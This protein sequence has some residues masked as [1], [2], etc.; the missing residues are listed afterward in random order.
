[1]LKTKSLTGKSQDSSEQKRNLLTEMIGQHNESAGVCPLSLAQQRLWFLEQLEPS[2]AAHQLCSGLRLTGDL[3]FHVLRCAVASILARHETLRTAFITLGGEVFQRIS[4][5]ADVEIPVVDLQTIPNNLREREAYETACAEARRPFDLQASPLL[6]LKLIKMGRNDYIFLFTMHHLVSDG[7]S[8][9]VFVEELTEFYESRMEGRQCRLPRLSIQ[10]SDF[11]RWQRES[12]EGEELDRQIRYWKTRL[13]GV[14]SLLELPADR[15]RTAEQAFAC[16]ALSAPLS[17][18][19]VEGLKAL[20]QRNDTTLFGVLL[21]AFNV[22]LYRYS[23][24]EDVCVGVS[25][26]GRSHVET[27][28][29]I[30][31]FVNTLVIRTDMSGNPRFRDLLAQVRDVL[32]DAQANQDLPFEKVVEEVQP[33]RSLA[34]HPLFQVMMTA[35][36]DPLRV[37]RFGSLTA[38]PYVVANS[39]SSLDLAAFVIEAA[40]G[41]LWWRLEYNTALFAPA[42]I[43]RMIRHYQTLLNSIVEKPE[44]RIED[45]DLLTLEELDKF[46]AW[47]NNVSKYPRTCVHELIADQ[48]ARSPNGIAVVFEDQSLTYAELHY[49]ARQVAAALRAAGA[50]LDSRVAICLERSLEMAAGVLGILQ[51]GAAYVPLDPAQPLERLSLMVE[52]AGAKLLLTQ[53]HL[54]ARV[55]RFFSS[56]VLIEDASTMAPGAPL[57]LQDPESLAYIMFTSGSTGRP[58]SVAVPHRAIVNLLT[59]MHTEPGLALDDRFLAV[60]NLCFDISALELF[61]PLV[62]GTRTVI[63]AKNVVSDGSKL[64][65]NLRRHGITIMQATPSTWRMLIGAGWNRANCDLKVLC[66]GETLTADLANQLIERSNSVWNLYGPTETTIWSSLTRVREHCPVSIG[67][68][69]QNTQF[70]VLD[71]RMRRVPVGIPGELYIGGDG[72]AAG[73]WNGSG[74]NRD[75]FV[76]NPFDS[77]GGRL[78]KT[79]D[80]VRYRDDGEIDYLGRLDWQVKVRGV[81]IE[82]GEVEAVVKQHADIR[83]AVAIVREDVP[84]DQR[85]VCYVVLQDGAAV[86]PSDLRAYI[87]DKLPDYMVPTL[88]FLDSLPLT[89][90]GKVERVSL[91]APV[92]DRRDREGPRNTFER[93]LL[94]IWKQV[95]RLDGIGIR[96]NFFDLGGHSLLA[97]HLLA[98]VERVFDRRLPVATIFTAQTVEQM[99]AALCQH[100]V[101]PAS[102]LVAIQD[103]G[104]LPPLFIIPGAGGNP[105]AY[106]DLGRFLGSNQ[107]V[108]VLQYPGLDGE[109]KPLERIEAI[110]EYFIR[111]IQKVQ[112]RGPYRLAGFCVGGLVAFE[113]AQQLV[114]SGEEAPLLALIETWHPSSIPSTHGAPAVLRPFLFLVRGM[115]R[116]FGAMLRLPPRRAVRYFREKSAIVKEMLLYRDIYRGDRQKR[117]RDLIF[118]AN[119]RA[120]SRY[121]PTAF[122]GHTQ[123]F[124]A[125]GRHVEPDKD[126]RLVWRDLS[127]SCD[128]VRNAAPDAM[129]LLGKPQVEIFA[130]NLAKW[131]YESQ[132]RA[133]K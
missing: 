57:E 103:R 35:L 5:N 105:L 101:K 123:L 112:P 71:R 27:E 59:S 118:E 41:T 70:Y 115:S 73:Y 108:Y 93:R 131:M 43:E 102:P 24:Q 98:E 54:A 49:R 31:L 130:N 8:M 67:R 20:G 84:G 55:S 52:D 78:Y 104:R 88:V 21:A 62:T 37:R 117:Y 76:P 74:L 80:E 90:N 126:T 47:N 92:E 122:A 96:D 13:A 69:I 127:E 60:T 42:R 3:D 94:L 15:A 97:M 58:K 10:Y 129:D 91:P 72:L 116:H 86:T 46:S 100:C 18:L 6:R 106:A 32:L 1:M 114:A 4:P 22:L 110:A 2:T 61:W 34:Y 9:G 65:E 133:A 75:G 79:G 128:V 87:K 77:A 56:Y 14:P 119:Y 29:L 85:L 40:D 23:N 30:G 132:M 82:L 81:R 12:M 39:T 120:G 45:L 7:C 53:R 19:T 107:P 17:I 89:A 38:S 48:S 51:T 83:Q 36:K 66:G 33:R 28:G 64:L 63:A 109:R 25:A 95:L 124:L 16:G 111:E 26:A 121:V 125:G 11:T 44:R 68:P 113:M 50:R 99:A